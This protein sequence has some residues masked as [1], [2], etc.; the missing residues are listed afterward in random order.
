MPK[1]QSH[2]RA[3]AA[4]GYSKKPFRLLLINYA[5]N[6]KDSVFAHQIEVVRKLAPFYLSIE[7]TTNDFKKESLPDNVTVSIVKWRPGQNLRNA[8]RFLIIF[9]KVMWTSRPK[10]VFSHMTEVQSALIAPFLRLIGKPHLLWYAHTSKSLSLRFTHFFA[11]GIVT[12]TPGS[13][14]I[15]SPKIFPIGQA[16]DEALFK[17]ARSSFKRRSIKAI[18]IGRLDPSKNILELISTLSSERFR[19]KFKSL[20]LIGESTINNGDYFQKILALTQVQNPRFDTTLVGPVPRNELPRYLKS[21][22]VFVHAFIGSLDK[23]LVEATMSGIPVV[24]NNP[25][26]HS[27]FGTWSQATS[28]ISPTFAEELEAYLSTNQ[29]VVSREI[30]KRRD[31][32]KKGHSLDS[33]INNLAQILDKEI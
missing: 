13:C 17:N 23:S 3:N 2:E 15:R 16:V 29:N 6:S 11:S 5:M 22:D 1:K 14:P 33:W 8:I 27:S 12:S 32:A 24:T 19:G 25:E 26:Y 31:L 20:T 28:R 4:R 30:K 9:F 18:H 7:V 21:H 10:K